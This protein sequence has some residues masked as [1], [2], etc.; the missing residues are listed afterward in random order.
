[1]YN[2]SSESDFCHVSVHIYYR[3]SYRFIWKH[4]YHQI[5]GLT[6]WSRGQVGCN[7]FD[8]APNTK[9]EC[10]EEDDSEA[11]GNG[12]PVVC[13]KEASTKGK[14]VFLKKLK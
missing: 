14:Y 1:M 9:I 13:N 11:R 5:K 10:I 7:C 8:A 12:E 2:N 3:L 6:F 4:L